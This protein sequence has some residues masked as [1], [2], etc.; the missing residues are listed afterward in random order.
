MNI[1]ETN[2]G[3][4]NFGV[5]TLQR[6]S[7]T[8]TRIKLICE[9]PPTIHRQRLHIDAVKSFF[10]DAGVLMSLSEKS[11][12][13]LTKYSKEV[14]ELKIPSKII[15]GKQIQFY[16]YRLERRLYQI[17]REV[18]IVLNKYYMPTKDYDE[19]EY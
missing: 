6:I 4:F 16:D 15:R 2:E 12:N 13:E 14:D 3:K 18:A 10:S 9:L 11:R 7:Q 5:D 1:M 17:V 19:D 8:L